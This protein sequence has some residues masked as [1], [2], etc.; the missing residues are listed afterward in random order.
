MPGKMEIIKNKEKLGCILNS[1]SGYIVY[2]AGLVAASLIQYLIKTRMSS[3][4]ICIAV[5]SKDGNPSDL[6]GVP[7]CKLDE[8]G[9][10]KEKYIFLIATL[11]HLQ[12]QIASELE[13]FGCNK[14]FGIADLFYAAI[15]EEVND[16]TPD[17]LCLLQ[18]NILKLDKIKEEL[19]CRIEEQ[20]EISTV[21]TQA[22]GKY[23][24]CFRGRDVV[25]MATGPSLNKYR[26]IE[27]AVHIGINTTYKNPDLPLD[28]LFVQDGRPEFLKEKFKGL[29]D[30]R[31]KVFIG[32]LLMSDHRQEIVF[33]EN[34]R[35]AQNV[36]DYMLESFGPDTKI[37]KNICT[38]PVSGW[39]SVVFSALHFAFFTYPKRIFLVGCDVA[40]TGYYDGS[41]D[42]KSLINDQ[43]VIKLKE[44]YLL[45]KKFGET[46]YPDTEII[47]INPVGLKSMFQ[48][49]YTN[50][51]TE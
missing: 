17:I 15:R 22:F 49:V 46:C 1:S 5:K 45:M 16:Y 32:R 36:S 7:V 25:L 38:H 43:A 44:G 10:Y 27:N 28:F 31:C 19:I 9:C 41:I 11:E 23:R 48:D 3:K 51:N 12:G 40:P 18:R 33:P 34:Y 13:N 50:A 29:E 6:M 21:N 39:L 2:G 4:L 30:V 26:P 24:N 14:I 35:L 20:N 42:E 47:S 37:Y 8:L